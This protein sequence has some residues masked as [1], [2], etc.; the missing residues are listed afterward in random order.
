MGWWLPREEIPIH[1]PIPERILHPDPRGSTTLSVSFCHI[2]CNQEMII[3][4]SMKKLLLLLLR[5]RARTGLIK[6]AHMVI[7]N[8]HETKGID[9]MMIVALEQ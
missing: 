7:S 3:H 1:L 4:S 5:L 6:W 2:Q 8:S 9:D